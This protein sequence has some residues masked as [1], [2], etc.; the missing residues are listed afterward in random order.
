MSLGERL[1]LPLGGLSEQQP[2]F[3][4]P[5]APPPAPR[6]CSLCTAGQSINAKQAV[7]L[8]T[9]QFPGVAIFSP[10]YPARV[11]DLTS[12]FLSF[13]PQALLGLSLWYKKDPLLDPF[14]VFPFLHIWPLPSRHPGHSYILPGCLDPPCSGILGY[15]QLPQNFEVWAYTSCLPR[16]Y[17][18]GRFF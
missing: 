9:G 12:T 4:T 6:A 16:K 15:C 17:Q 3:H 10:T 13:L 5:G 8:P 1:L 14:S 7:W 2:G 18:K 11:E